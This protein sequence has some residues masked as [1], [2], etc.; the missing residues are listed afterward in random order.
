M[1]RNP[2]PLLALLLTLPLLALACERPPV[3]AEQTG[4]RGVAMERVENPRLAEKLLAANEVPP[5]ADPVPPAGQPASTIFQNLQVLGHVDAAEFT[6][7][8]GAL[9]LW[10]SPEQGCAYCHAGGNFAAE[11]P[12]APYTKTV[13]RRMLQM[14]M[15]I[16]ANWKSHVRNT[17]VTC[18]TC[19]RGQPVPEEI[20]YRSPAQNASFLGYDAGQNTPAVGL[21][22]LPA[23]PFTAYLLLQDPLDAR[24]QSDTALPAGSDRTIKDTEWTYGFMVHISESL[25]VNCTHCH[26]SRAFGRW[27]QSS[28][29]RANAWHAIRMTREVNSEYIEPLADIFP[30]NRK[31][32]AGDPYKANCETCHRG[33]PQP[34]QGV[35]MLASH[36]ELAAPGTAASTARPTPTPAPRPT[37]APEPAAA[38]SPE[39]LSP[40]TPGASAP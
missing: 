38:P 18:Y 39:G 17:G 5:P 34:L 2:H 3:D 19:H 25:G 24:V 35:S 36:P 37:P 15:Q 23:D 9:T 10:V 6:R 31:G 28:P 33:L 29:A 26:N 40:P 21:T 1:S 16:N 4:F 20:W 11:Y 32:P 12:E 30:D 8:M 27:E 13:S 14:T 7:L 22:S